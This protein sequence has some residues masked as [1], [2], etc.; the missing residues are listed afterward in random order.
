LTS[1]DGV[2]TSVPGFESFF[3]TSASA[4]NAAAVAGLVLQFSP[5]FTPAQLR[6]ALDAGT[7][8]IGAAGYDL[9]TGNGLLDAM[10]VLLQLNGGVLPINGDFDSAG[11]NDDIRLRLLAGDASE[12]EILIN[13]VS[14][15]SVRLQFVNSIAV[16][17]RGG[18]DTLTLDFSNGAFSAPGGIG[19][20]GGLGTDTLS[21]VGRPGAD[22]VVLSITSPLGNHT[23]TGLGQ[24]V[25]SVSVERVNIDGKGGTNSLAI[26]DNTNLTYGTALSPQSGLIFRPTGAASGEFSIAG[27]SLSPDVNFKAI[28][29][30]FSVNGDGN[31]SGDRDTFTVLAA[32]TAGRASPFGEITSANG[33]D[34][35]NASDAGV[36]IRNAALGALRGVTLARTGGQVTF[37]N[38]IVRAGNE[39]G[40]AGDVVNATPSNRL[41]LFL[42]GMDPS[43]GVSGDRLNVLTTG[44]R[45]IVHSS[46]PSL[47]PPQTRVVQSDGASVGYVHFEGLAGSGVIAVA[48]GTGSGP[49]VR[50]LDAAT[51]APRFDLTPFPGFAGGL[52]V[53]TGDLTGDAVPDIVVS[54]GAAGPAHVVAFDGLTGALIRSFI[55]FEGY[56]GGVT[57]AA[58]D[59]NGDGLADIIV[60]TA[61][62]TSH[63]KVFDGRTG[64]LLNSFLAFPG[65]TSGVNVGAGDVTGDG[66][67]DV[68]AGAVGG[69]GHVK[70]FDG[71]SGALARSFLAFGGLFGDSSVAG[72]DLDGDG[73]AEVLVGA[74]LSGQARAF[75]G[76]TGGQTAG[77]TAYP[78]FGGEVRVGAADA[79]GDGRAELLTGTGPGAAPHV[80]RFDGRSLALLDSFFA[81]EPTFTGGIYLG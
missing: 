72:A 25:S 57:V 32:S 31:G 45:A 44:G 54:V 35:I 81:F 46:D 41:N 76:R 53:A 56:F 4:P 51:G 19:F 15:G 70:V 77:L 29:G 13:G 42:D 58:G 5:S 8:D 69:S 3:G 40:P 36:T 61:A 17:G 62:R 34:L 23:L 63:V 6:S 26:V 74:T 48:R 20:V 37:R 1:N 79:D 64:G 30:S 47:G 65:L 78:G 55:A 27:G 39:S 49:Q 16:D 60:G 38:L 2:S 24:P 66:F 59:V 18:N 9:V 7:V 52:R 68:I 33:T 43:S 12:L 71:A 73:F 11:E 67:C 14:F 50:V 10:G 22:S 21:F 80:D 28:N 75:D